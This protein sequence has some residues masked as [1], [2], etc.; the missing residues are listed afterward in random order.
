MSVNSYLNF[1][2]ECFLTEI[3]V[4]FNSKLKYLGKEKI[5]QYRIF[6]F[7]FRSCKEIGAYKAV[8]SVSSVLRALPTWVQG[9]SPDAVV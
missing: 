7:P 1:E 9:Q 3:Q 5:L 6:F 2:L 8:A 4:N